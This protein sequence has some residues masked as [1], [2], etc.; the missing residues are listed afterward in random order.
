MKMFDPLLVK[1]VKQGNAIVGLEVEEAGD[2]V[3]VSADVIHMIDTPWI[4]VDIP[5]KIIS[6]VDIHGNVYNYR[7]GLFNATDNLYLLNKI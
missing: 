1:Y 7:F 6:I 4:R 3:I 2:T 5:D